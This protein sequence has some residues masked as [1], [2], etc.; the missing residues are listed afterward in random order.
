MT[1]PRFILLISALLA[2]LLCACG[3]TAEP[4]SAPEGLQ[5]FGAP[6]DVSAQPSTGPVAS[7]TFNPSVSA[8][9]V[10]SSGN[11]VENNSQPSASPVAEPSPVRTQTPTVR[12]SA[13]AAPVSP[14][15]S[16]STEPSPFSSPA[17]SPPAPASSA[18]PEEAEEFVGRP[19]R[20][21]IDELGVPSR[22]DYEPVDEEDPEQ[23]EIG[24]L[25]FNGFTVTTFKDS[26]GETITSVNP[27]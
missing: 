11:L 26:E 8:Q 24:T 2:L 3:D 12:P 19:V 10:P 1:K 25:Y 4:S 20:E 22:S 5:T 15:P 9:P 18:T 21:L 27:D 23:G 13:S 7:P 14:S 17:I 6:I 16:P